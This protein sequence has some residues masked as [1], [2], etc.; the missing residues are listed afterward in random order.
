MSNTRWVEAIQFESQALTAVANTVTE[1]LLAPNLVLPAR[2]LRGIRAFRIRAWGQ[3]STTLTPT[4][5]FRVRLGG[6]GT[7]AD[8][9]VAASSAITTASG[10]TTLIW[11]LD[12]DM[13]V[14]SDTLGATA[15]NVMGIGELTVTDAATNTKVGQM[16]P[17][18]APAV[19]AGYNV[20]A[21]NNLGTYVTWSAASASNT[22]TTHLYT[23]ESLT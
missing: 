15:A 20:E 3:F 12:F 17:A 23:V 14:R 7:N 22:L 6:A 8:A 11:R 10:A 13:V 1:T 19:S 16:V 4:L 18:S 2:Y 5:T 9:A 21:Q